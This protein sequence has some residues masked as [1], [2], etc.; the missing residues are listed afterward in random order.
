[1]HDHRLAYLPGKQTEP[2]TKISK[3]SE[4]LKWKTAREKKKLISFGVS[5]CPSVRM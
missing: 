3:F 4:R 1:M 5:A 2:Q